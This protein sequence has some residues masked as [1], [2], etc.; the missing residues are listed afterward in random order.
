MRCL[1]YTSIETL[2]EAVVHGANSVH[3]KV[4]STGR[5]GYEY[6]N[7]DVYKRQVN[8]FNYKNFDLTVDFQ[9]TWGVDVMQEYYHSTVAR[10]LTNGL[11]RIY[12]DAWHP[13]LNPNRCV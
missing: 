10:F 3:P 1:L 9:Y 7:E 6:Y 8:T 2:W 11:D 12:T 13:T 4:K 5:L